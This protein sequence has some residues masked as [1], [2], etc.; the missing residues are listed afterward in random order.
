MAFYLSGSRLEILLY[1]RLDK[2][3]HTACQIDHFGITD[4]A[5]RRQKHLIAGI[6]YCHDSVTQR[7]LGSCRDYYL[8]RLVVKIVFAF[9]L[10]AA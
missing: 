6:Y 8:R 2:D 1:S 3:R 4:P 9:E 10:I 5:G 7:L